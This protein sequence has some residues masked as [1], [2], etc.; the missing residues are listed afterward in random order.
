MPVTARCEIEIHAPIETVWAVMIDLRRYGEWN[1]FIVEVRDAP[2]VVEVG[3]QFCL[4][5]RWVDG[6]G[7]A[8][9]GET[10]VEL[11]APK[12]EGK[13]TSA[14][15]TYDFTSWLRTL[16]LL[17]TRRT[18]WLEQVDREKVVYRSEEIFRGPLCRFIPLSRVQAGFDAH[19]RALKARAEQPA[20]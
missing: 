19:A 14:R 15:L 20:S 18:Q 11:V 17:R 5:V 8:T 16:R 7:R 4:M 9:A 1:P 12:P 3:S 13:G 2:E 10:V 6:S